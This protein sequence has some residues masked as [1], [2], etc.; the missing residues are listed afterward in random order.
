MHMRRSSALMWAMGFGLLL[1]AGQVGAGSEQ[2]VT[3]MLGGKFCD[4]YTDQVGAALKK[5]PGVKTVDVK[6]MKGHAIVDTEAG[7]VKPAQLTDAVKTVK[8]EG[9]FCTAEIMK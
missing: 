1:A 6:S 7:K 5:V 2:K 4:A 3:L 9:W 8:G